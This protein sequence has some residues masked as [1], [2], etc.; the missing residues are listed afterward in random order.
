MSNIVD[1]PPK[2]DTVTIVLQV[3]LHNQPTERHSAL[4]AVSWLYTGHCEWGLVPL[5]GF[6]LSA[7]E[8]DQDALLA[9]PVFS[10]PFE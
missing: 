1:P 9:R 4:R 6:N 5:A 7:A 10:F 3:V 2:T 8:F